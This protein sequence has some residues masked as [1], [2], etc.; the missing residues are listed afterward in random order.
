MNDVQTSTLSVTESDKRKGKL[1]LLGIVAVFVLPFLVLPLMMS[2]ENM[3]KTNKGVL[4]QPH[5]IFA[6]LHVTDVKNLSAVNG[7]WTL[8]YF[9]PDVC[10][11]VCRN[12]LYSLRQ[13]PKTLA[14]DSDRVQT[15]LVTTGDMD[16]D[17]ATL[18][19]KEFSAMSQAR[20]DKN[21]VKTLFQQVMPGVDVLNAS[22]IYLMS[23]DGY[24]FMHYPSYENEQEA[25]NHALDIHD[26][27]K[28]SIKGSRL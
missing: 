22:Y 1:M 8:L 14:R 6:E 19:D 13:V 2:P 20:A 7:K 10:E 25:I 26:D 17:L 28:K 4:I 24:I 18:V 12:A 11:Q 3:R 21:T 27:L 16:M 15:L 5:V 9:V 23:P